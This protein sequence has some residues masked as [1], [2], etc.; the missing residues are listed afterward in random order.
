MKI[1]KPSAKHLKEKQIKADRRSKVLTLIIIGLIIIVVFIGKNL[2][3]YGPDLKY[4]KDLRKMYGSV[5]PV[6]K[7]CMSGDQVKVHSTYK[8]NC[9]GEIFAAC[10]EN[11]EKK[12]RDH[13]EQEA[14]S[15]DTITGVKIL[16]SKA[17]PGF[18]QKGELN[19]IY[20]ENMKTF[21]A[22]YQSG[23]KSKRN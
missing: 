23:R 18:R 3:M 12:I 17:I 5:I 10:C 2:V 4:H 9:N 8:F 1:N 7:V 20:F 19:V 21:Q 6:E 15:L 16:K 13:Y 11:C 14:Y 22:Y